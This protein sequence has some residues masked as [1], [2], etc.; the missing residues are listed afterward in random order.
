MADTLDSNGLTLETY[1]S[2]LAFVQNSM[3]E[4]YATDGDLINFDS[5]TPDGQFTNIL[6]QISADA[7][8]LAAEIYNSFNP[9]N[10]QGVVQDQRYAL[11]YI[12]RKAGTFTVQNID[13]TVD[14]TVDLQG[15]DGD[16]N[17]LTASSYTVS[18]NAGNQWYLIDSTTLTT[19]TTSLPFRSQALGL[20]QPTIGTITNQVTKV[21]GVTNVINSIAPTTLGEDEESDLEFRIRRNSSTAIYGQNNYDAMLGQLLQITGV[22][23]AKIFVNNTL[24]ANTDV[25]DKVGGIPSRSVWVIVEG[26]ANDDIATTIY[27]NSGGLPTIGDVTVDVPTTSQQIFT[28]NFDRV[29]P[30]PFYIQFELKNT[31]DTPLI[32]VQIDNIKTLIVNSLDFGLGSPVETSAI[33]EAAAQALLTYGSGLYALNVEISTDG[34]TWTDFI[35][36]ASWQNKYVADVTRINITQ[37]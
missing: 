30:V 4:I 26:G 8:Q 21:L 35:S 2:I 37:A 15:L 11:N 34:E 27:Q 18:D 29:N 17:S 36:N 14:R 10:C 13:V 1:N 33:T 16:Y 20:V 24:N 5:E 7:R 9:D 12:T 23:D 6:A 19:G 3:N 28:V 25:T 31:T 22:T 32:E